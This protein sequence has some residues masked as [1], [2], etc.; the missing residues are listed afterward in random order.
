[1][2]FKVEENDILKQLNE[3]SGFR[4]AS[5]TQVNLENSEI[6]VFHNYLKQKEN[7]LTRRSIILP[8]SFLLKMTNHLSFE[9]KSKIFE[10]KQDITCH[11]DRIIVRVSAM[12]SIVFTH[13]IQNIKREFEH[14]KTLPVFPKFSKYTERSNIISINRAEMYTQVSQMIKIIQDGIQIVKFIFWRLTF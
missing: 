8:F 13:A 2:I 10:G 5:S 12:D 9:P 1:M 7:V 11:I 14:Y 3:K 6:F 4:E